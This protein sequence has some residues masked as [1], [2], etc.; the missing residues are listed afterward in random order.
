[1]LACNYTLRGTL[2]GVDFYVCTRCSHGEST[3]VGS[4]PNARLCWSDHVCVFTLGGEFGRK[5]RP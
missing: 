2:D 1:M 4:R 3:V 5:S